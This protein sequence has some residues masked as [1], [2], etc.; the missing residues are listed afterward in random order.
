MQVSPHTWSAGGCRRPRGRNQGAYRA[1]RPS[2]ALGCPICHIQGVQYK[3][4]E[5]RWR[6]TCSD[7]HKW[8]CDCNEW[9]V[10]TPG[11]RVSAPGGLGADIMGGGIS[12][13]TDSEDGGAGDGGTQDGGIDGTG[14]VRRY[15]ESTP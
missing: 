6:K 13:T 7:L 2:H 10:H 14:D 12:F 4:A 15:F 1:M 9:W 8:W 11:W 3:R 5:A